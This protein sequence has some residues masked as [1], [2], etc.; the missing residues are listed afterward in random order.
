MDS[1]FLGESGTGRPERNSNIVP[2]AESAFE[3]DRTV[4]AGHANRGKQ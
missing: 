4:G 3:I 1:C 2:R